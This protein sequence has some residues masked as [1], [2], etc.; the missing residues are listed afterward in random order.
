MCSS[1]VSGASCQRQERAPGWW[2]DARGRRREDPAWQPF[3][4]FCLVLRCKVRGGIRTNRKAA[5]TW[6]KPG[7]SRDNTWLHAVELIRTHFQH[8]LSEQI[9]M[10]SCE[11]F[12]LDYEVAL[13]V[14]ASTQQVL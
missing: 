5:C 8:K 2:D 4:C 7:E 9:I 10:R 3:F 6:A 1:A 13:R 14:K 11:E 12:I